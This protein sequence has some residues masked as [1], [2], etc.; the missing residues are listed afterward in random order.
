MNAFNAF[1]IPTVLCAL[2]A[3]IGCQSAPR[4][5]DPPK[6]YEALKIQ[7]AR[8]NNLLGIDARHY[9]FTLRDDQKL[10]VTFHEKK[11]GKYEHNSPEVRE[12][13]Y[14]TYRDF[15]LLYPFSKRVEGTSSIDIELLER[16]EPKGDGRKKISVKPPGYGRFFYFANEFKNNKWAFATNNFV[17]SKGV[18]TLFDFRQNEE[19]GVL[20]T[21]RVEAE[22]RSTASS[23]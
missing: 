6:D 18:V 8:L 17:P 15:N 2:I 22:I 23:R 16:G 14:A 9:L 10:V 11:N 12:I 5:N 3:L 21:L 19:G 7:V 20:R 13:N 1:R 4:S